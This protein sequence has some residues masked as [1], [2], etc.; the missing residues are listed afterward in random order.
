MNG[1]SFKEGSL[2][3]NSSSLTDLDADIYTIYAD[4]QNYPVM[5]ILTEINEATMDTL[6]TNTESVG[7]LSGTAEWEARWTAW[8]F[9]VLAALSCV[10]TILGF[11]HNDLHTNN[12]V[13]SKT[14][15]P[16]LYYKTK[17]DLTFRVPTF[18]KIFKII[19]FGRAIFTINSQIFISDDFKDDNDAAGQYIFSPLVK[20]FKKEILPN[21]SFDMCRLAV[22]L[23]DG[24]FPKRPEQLEEGV[25]LSKE[26]GLI[27][28]ETGSPLYNILWSWM[29]DDRGRTVFMNPDGSERF[30]DFD[31]YK[32]IAEFVHGAVPSRQIVKPIFE[33]FQISLKDIP[34]G[35]KMY[36]L[37]F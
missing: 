20:N 8:I 37:F 34:E 10:Q 17:G 13:W 6:F 1:V 2:S 23:L 31:L 32:H 22:S 29:V 36:S 3:S 4:I 7:A 15:E 9:Q 12:V 30:P 14:D 26:P 19:D 11:T 24:I 35:V 27:V 16:Y 21:P 18:G 5:L 33:P 28:K 25:I